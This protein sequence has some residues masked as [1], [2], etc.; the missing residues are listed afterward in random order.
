MNVDVTC[1]HCGMA[2]SV[3]VDPQFG[4][5][6]SFGCACTI[7]RSG[8][9]IVA[10][11]AQARLDVMQGTVTAALANLEAARAWGRLGRSAPE[12]DA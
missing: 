11:E 9:E 10:H 3:M 6:W 2:G 12:V 8:L 1:P 5:A 4:L 7:T